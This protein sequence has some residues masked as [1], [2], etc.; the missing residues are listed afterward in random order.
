MIYKKGFSF[1]EMIIIIAII[2]IM[3]SVMLVISLKERTGKELEAVGR[4]VT[5]AIREAQNNALTG[6]QQDNSKLPCAFLF[7]TDGM[8]YHMKGSYRDVGAPCGSDYS[9]TSY[10]TELNASTLDAEMTL[11]GTDSEGRISSYVGFIVPYGE[12]FDAGISETNPSQGTQFVLEKD[13]EKYYICVHSTGLIEELGF[14][15]GSG[16][17]CSF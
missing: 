5:S 6:K 4:E 13:G 16:T 1:L 12:Y 10:A 17:L 7:E 8:T 3:T 9:L 14:L 11:T 2:G 15:E